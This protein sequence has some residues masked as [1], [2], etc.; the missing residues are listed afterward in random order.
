MRYPANFSGL[1]KCNMTRATIRAQHPRRATGIHR[2]LTILSIAPLSFSA[3]SWL[4]ANGS[5]EN[6]YL[7]P[8]GKMSASVARCPICRVLPALRMI[9]LRPLY[10]FGTCD[11]VLG[12]VP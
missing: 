12:G 10:Y 6:T 9:Y 2:A 8:A 11:A 1:P 4:E 5:S 7:F 3:A